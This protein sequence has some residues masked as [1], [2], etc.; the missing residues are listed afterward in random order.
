MKYRIQ[1]AITTVLRA[2]ARDFVNAHHSYI[3][4]VDRPSRKMYW[5]LYEDDRHVGVFGIGSAFARPKPVAEYM[6][7]RGLAFNEVA[8]NI[9]YALFA[10]QDRNSGTRFLRLLRNDAVLWWKE[11]YGGTP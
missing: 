10:C 8:N 2:Q 3:Q 9:V 6:T 11:R 5:L 1:R 7:E 4:W